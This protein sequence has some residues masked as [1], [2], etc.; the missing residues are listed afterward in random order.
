MRWT[1]FIVA[2]WS[3]LFAV[4]AIHASLPA[5]WWFDAGEIQI[6][7]RNDGTCPPM[8]FDRT[9]ERPFYGEWVVTILR[10]TSSGG[11]ATYRT[12]Q[13]ANDYQPDVALPDDL[14]LC[15]WVWSISLGVPFQSFRLELSP[16]RYRVTTLWT[17]NPDQ[18]TVK[19]VRRTSNV[20]EVTG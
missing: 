5:S 6:E 4:S 8:A 14:N 18:K 11:F 20:F 16:G 7:P 13:G 9:I 1:A 10:E 17:I 12:F 2:A 15:W 19:S 3:I